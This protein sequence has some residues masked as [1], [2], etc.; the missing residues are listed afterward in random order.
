LPGYRHQWFSLT[1]ADC[2][3]A[4]RNNLVVKAVI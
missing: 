4:H 1:L 2:L 3:P